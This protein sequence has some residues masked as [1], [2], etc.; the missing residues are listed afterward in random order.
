[1]AYDDDTMISG[2]AERSSNWGEQLAGVGMLRFK[3]LS[4]AGY[5]FYAPDIS[6]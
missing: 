2:A 5:T 4:G 1:M 3:G 6:V